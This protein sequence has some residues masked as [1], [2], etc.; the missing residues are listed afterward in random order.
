ADGG[1]L[2]RKLALDGNPRG[3]RQR[4]HPD[5]HVRDA[6]D[7]AWK[8]PPVPPDAAE[9]RTEIEIVSARVMPV[10]GRA[11]HRNVAHHRTPHA[12]GLGGDERA[13]HQA[14]AAVG[15]DDD[16]GPEG[17]RLGLDTNA[18]AVA[19]DAQDPRA[20]AQRDTALPRGPCEA[21]VELAPADHAAE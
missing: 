14:P 10:P 18:G 6:V 9:K 20:L 3:R 15:A 5:V 13:S 2:A 4:I 16:G 19:S 11:R 7:P 8:R 21:G 1:E 17:L 12:P